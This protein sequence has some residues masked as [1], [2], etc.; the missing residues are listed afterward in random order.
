MKE[1]IV[2]QDLSLQLN[3]IIFAISEVAINIEA[4]RSHLSS[5][6]KDIHGTKK[7]YKKDFK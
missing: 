7:R 5:K 2:K 6:N 3:N 4:L 1:A